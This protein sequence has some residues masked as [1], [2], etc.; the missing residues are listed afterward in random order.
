MTPEPTQ[1][2]S[3]IPS[4]AKP[5]SM[6]PR[7]GYSRIAILLLSALFS[8][9]ASAAILNSNGSASD[10]QAKIDM[11]SNGDT[12]RL[13]G[14]G[15]YVWSSQVGM[16]SSK[17]ITLDLNGS[18]ITLSGS[19]GAF[20]I[21]AHATGNNRVTNGA[22]VRGTGYGQFNG[23]FNIED[24]RGQAGVIVDNITFSGP[25][26]IIDMNGRGPGVM[27]NCTFIGLEW[28]Q[29]FIHILGWGPSSEFG[30]Q[31]D[32]GASLAGSGNIFYIENC[33]FTGVN[34]NGS[35]W[36]QGYYGCRVAIRHCL[37]T[38]ASIDMHGTPGAIGARWWEVYNNTWTKNGSGWLGCNMRA[39][40]GVIFNNVGTTTAEIGLVEEDSGYPAKYQIGR[41]LNQV[42]D[43][44]Y[45]WNNTRIDIYPNGGDAPPQPNMVLANRDYYQSQRPGYT[46]FVYPHPLASGSGAPP[47]LPPPP[48]SPIISVTGGSQDFGTV[49]VGLSSDRSLTVQNIGTGT[50]VGTAT[51]TL[52]FSI[53]SSGS[54]SLGPN[55]S[56]VVTVRY[57]P[58]TSGVSNAVATFTGG[59][60]ASVALTGSAVP[61]SGLP[62]PTLPALSWESTAGV[63]QSPFVAN[64]TYISQPLETLNPSAGGQA[65]YDFEITDPGD[66]IISADVNAPSNGANSFYVN[67]DSQPTAP[68]MIWDTPITA[69]FAN[70]TVSWRGNGSDGNNQF[71]P[72]IFSLSAGVHRLIIRG[73]EANVQLGR[74][75]ISP[76]S[77]QPQAPSNLRV[78]PEQ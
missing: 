42:S 71:S 14:S 54:Y 68:T 39:G 15:S 28:A 73:R 62:Q 13:P 32:S 19:S 35:A 6:G 61:T 74:I 11:A 45:I 46:P 23:P 69:G 53:I 16:P 70:A 20:Y 25:Y 65:T 33:S 9:S 34:S 10:T 4:Q 38:Q 64:S 30:W 22:I 59:G 29:E 36:I 77:S 37:F 31:N 12:V 55:Q 26:V 67:I 21:A 24:E 56:Q 18:T 3:A 52:P 44:A 66:Y 5:S 1:T 50:L 43:P 40:S 8:L 27:Y 60:G 49:Q 51:T 72:K 47:P 63:V 7:L 41:G 17:Y 76:L 75:T 48:A 78:L 2:E 57:S 58:L